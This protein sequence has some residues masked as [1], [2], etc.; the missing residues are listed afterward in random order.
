MQGTAC[1]GAI[2]RWL[3]QHCLCAEYFSRQS[4]PN[5][6]LTTCY[7]PSKLMFH[8]LADMLE[9]LPCAQFFKRQ[10]SKDIHPREHGKI[11]QHT[12]HI[13]KGKHVSVEDMHVARGPA[14]TTWEEVEATAARKSIYGG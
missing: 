6:L 14:K 4:A 11:S 7:R 8:F 5:V 10:V 3:I 2:G 9:V 12:P 13:I 1:L